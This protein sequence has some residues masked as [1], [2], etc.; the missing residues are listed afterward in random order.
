MWG[1]VGPDKVSHF[2]DGRSI[3]GVFVASGYDHDT[4]DWVF[5]S[6]RQFNRDFDARWHLL[7]PTTVPIDDERTK[8]DANTFNVA[9]AEELRQTYGLR[10]KELP[11]IVF[12]NFNDEEPQLFIPLRNRDSEQLRSFFE[13]CER[14]MAID[15]PELA[16]RYRYRS[17]IIGEIVNEDRLKQLT[18]FVA[19]LVKS[20]GSIARIMSGRLS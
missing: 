11:G 20:T 17:E 13:A 3:V 2:E 19:R 18:P 1:I 8:I 5:R 7:I 10:R 4:I 12:E 15:R 16:N 14:R 9:L 6:W